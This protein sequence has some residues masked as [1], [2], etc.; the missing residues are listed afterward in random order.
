[1]KETKL[2]INIFC[3]KSKLIGNG[4][5]IRSKRLLK[6][7][8]NKK[9]NC[10]LYVNKNNSELNK[11]VRTS[12]E[13]FKLILD[14]KSYEKVILK[15]TNKILKTISFENLSNKNFNNCINLYPLDIQYKKFS[16]PN[17]F[18]YPYYFKKMKKKFSFQRKRYLNILI[19]QGGTD[20]NNNLNKITKLLI[21]NDLK[22]NFRIILKTNDIS[23]VNKKFYSNK[24]IKV[25]G[26]LKSMKTIFKK[27]DIALSACGNLAFELGYFGIPTI[28]ITKEPREISR[29]KT[30]FKKNLGLYCKILEEKKIKNELNKIVFNNSYR[31]KL[32]NR[33]I[34]FFRKTNLITEY[35]K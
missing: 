29:A 6:Y 11:I 28:H 3:E 34:S 12:K 8:R 10:K 1:M 19:I 5:Y 25:I 26:K 14:L 4:H 15:D 31:N 33:R 21:N 23:S 30:L 16:G 17:Y 20:A 9:F 32:I 2:K 22:F 24:Y 27:T 7:L 18:V 13:R 35:L